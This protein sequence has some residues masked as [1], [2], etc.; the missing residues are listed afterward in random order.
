MQVEYFGI[1]DEVD[2]CG[3]CGKQGLRKAVML[4]VLD[5]EG[6]REELIYFGTT[7]A[8]R[9]LNL[10]N[11]QVMRAAEDA[12][13]TRQEKI[14]RLTLQLTDMD[15][16]GRFPMETRRVWGA[17]TRN[18][19]TVAVEGVDYG[20]KCGEGRMFLGFATAIVAEWKRQLAFL[21]N[22]K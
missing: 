13:R 9:A 6:N 4:F 11:S 20:P 21:T 1:T 8:A 3:H 17:A 5:A 10:R 19:G 15:P 12:E 22:G 2:E 14:R 16:M 18:G 7:C